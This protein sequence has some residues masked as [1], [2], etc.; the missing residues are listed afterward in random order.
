M[1]M[2]MRQDL[3]SAEEVKSF[4]IRQLPE[5]THRRAKVEA[6]RQGISMQDFIIRAIE[7]ALEI[8][9]KS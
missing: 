7:L 9:E 6:A 3:V 5:K 4:T 8:A 1:K 2:E